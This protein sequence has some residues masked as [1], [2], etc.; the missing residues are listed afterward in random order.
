MSRPHVR[1]D[2]HGADRCAAVQVLPPQRFHR[3]DGV[4]VLLVGGPCSALRAGKEGTRGRV[5]R[6]RDL[7]PMAKLQSK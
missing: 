4:F 6:G 3:V 7:Q 1:R 5:Q 2:R